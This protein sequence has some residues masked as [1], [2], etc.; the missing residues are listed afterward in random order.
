MTLES[1]LPLAS[2]IMVIASFAVG[3]V[4]AG[5][6]QGK[7]EGMIL[8]ELGYVKSS[9]DD[10]KR[11]LDTQDEHYAEMRAK[12]SAIDE[13]VKSAHNRIDEIRAHC[14]GD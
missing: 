8:G 13:S 10:V 1:L 9:V 5:K 12:I 3:R 14:C 6:D 11:K 2:F 4:S 7:Q